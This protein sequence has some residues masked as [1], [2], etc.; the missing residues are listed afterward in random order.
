MDDKDLEVQKLKQMTKDLWKKNEDLKKEVKTLQDQIINIF[1]NYQFLSEPPIEK[2]QSLK[3]QINKIIDDAKE[4]LHVITPIIDQD[5]FG[6]LIDKSNQNVKIFICTLDVED[7][8]K[9]KDAQKVLKALK[10]DTL[11]K[12]V[13]STNLNSVA[14]LSDK[15]RAIISSGALTKN[16]IL[17]LSNIGM[18]LS[19]REDLNK[20]IRYLN[21]NFPGFM[22]IDLIS[23][24][25]EIKIN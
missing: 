2:G 1:G 23:G 8:K 17:N 12:S 3:D 10:S 6:K 13:T 4:D 18:L 22:S 14:I 19:F 15:K 20:C 16:D 7:V 5:Y 21:K 11:I 24:E 9:N 25:E